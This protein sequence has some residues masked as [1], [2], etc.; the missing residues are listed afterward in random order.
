LGQTLTQTQIIQ[1]LGDALGWFERELGWGVKPADLNHLTGRIGELYAAMITRGQMALDTNQW[2]Y[3]VVSAEGE[4]I[5][6]KTVTSSSHV[7]FNPVTLSSVD[8]IIVLR[9][10][11]DEDSGISIEELL[12]APLAEAK[13]KFVDTGDKLRFAVRSPV[14]N[15]L[16]PADLRVTNTADFDGVKIMRYE[17]GHIRLERDGVAI[18]PAKPELRHIAESIGISITAENGRIRTTHELGSQIVKALKDRSENPF[19]P[20]IIDL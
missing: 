5:S 4:K 2:G 8:R 1:S 17:N 20:R 16:V 14:S 11:V 18:L 15:K 19:P 10:N 6:V 12:D 13:L 3:D 7:L 9:I